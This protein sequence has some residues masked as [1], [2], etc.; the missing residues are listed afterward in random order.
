VLATALTDDFGVGHRFRARLSDE[1]VAAPDLIYLEVASACRRQVRLGSLSL[2]RA[3]EALAD[4]GTYPIR[5]YAH[6]QLVEGCW[7]LRDVVSIYD[8]AYVSLAAAL[9]QPLLTADAK[10]ARAARSLCQVELLQ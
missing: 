1:S 8:A 5:E 6:R 2:A 4:L 10:L 9:D 7:R 3:H